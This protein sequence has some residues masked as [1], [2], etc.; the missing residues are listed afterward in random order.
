[1]IKKSFAGIIAVFLLLVM[2]LSVAASTAYTDSTTGVSFTVPDG[3]VE[4]ALGEEREIIKVK[5]THETEDGSSIMFG[6]GDMWEQLTEDERVGYTREDLNHDAMREIFSNEELAD[7]LGLNTEGSIIEEVSYNWKEYV[8]ISSTSQIS[9]ASYSTD[10]TLIYLIHIQEG[11]M[12]MFCYGYMGENIH[13]QEFETFMNNVKYSD[14]HS[15][16]YDGE[17]IIVPNIEDLPSLEVPSYVTDNN[18]YVYDYSDNYD[19]TEYDNGIVYFED[20]ELKFDFLGFILSLIFTIAIYSFPIIIYRYAIKK[21]PI[22]EKKAKKITIIYGIIAFIV[23]AVLLGGAPGSAIILWSTVNYKMLTKPSKNDVYYPTTYE[24]ENINVNT[25]IPAA[26]PVE[27]AIQQAVENHVVNES[28]I[29]EDR[30]EG[31][32]LEQSEPEHKQEQS[33]QYTEPLVSVTAQEPSYEEQKQIGT[34]PQPIVTT[35]FSFC[36]KCGTKLTAE[37]EFCH[38]CGTRVIR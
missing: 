11:Y 26:L 25:P 17:E 8:K 28:E 15:F 12:F 21:Q 3:W 37:S 30:E 34:I 10:I 1:M 27:N 2:P 22:P 31:G 14:I 7:A 36:R 18:D 4:T 20:G 13:G 23:M 16:T 9:I 35:N 32:E 24:N 33:E 6:Y 19:T 5:Y 29:I 38:K